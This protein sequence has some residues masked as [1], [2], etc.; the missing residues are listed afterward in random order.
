MLKNFVP[1]WPIKRNQDTKKKTGRV[2]ES[3]PP[4]KRGIYKNEGN[5]HY[6]TF[7]VLYK[8]ELFL[9]ITRVALLIRV[10]SLFLDLF[11]NLTTT[12]SYDIYN[13]GASEIVVND[14]RF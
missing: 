1:A 5:I 13:S 9:K 2:R 4:K 6:M 7:G 14:Q 11:N 3:D 8:S 12:T 10:F